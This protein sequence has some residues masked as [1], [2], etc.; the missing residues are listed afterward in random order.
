MGM[1]HREKMVSSLRLDRDK[2]TVHGQYCETAAGSRLERAG[3]DAAC[4]EGIGSCGDVCAGAGRRWCC[5]RGTLLG[6]GSVLLAVAA[7]IGLWW[8]LAT[9][10]FST[11]DDGPS[12]GGPSLDHL[13]HCASTQQA[14]C[15]A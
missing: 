8:L 10:V 6:C 9:F 5:V 2:A 1:A 7:V 3:P 13:E 15:A 12:L 11:S 14:R 4:G